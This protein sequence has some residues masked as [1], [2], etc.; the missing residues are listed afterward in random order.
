VRTIRNP[1]RGRRWRW[2]QTAPSMY[3]R[4]SI[5]IGAKTPGNAQLDATTQ[6]RGRPQIFAPDL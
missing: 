5:E 6:S 4:P 2:A 3:R 1:S